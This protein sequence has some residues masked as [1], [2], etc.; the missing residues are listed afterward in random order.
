MTAIF[1][2]WNNYGFSL[3]SDSNQT[4]SKDN[5]TW[6]DPV[7]KV[8]LLEKHQIAIGAAGDSF[9]RGVEINEIFRTWERTLPI[10]GFPELGDYFVD[11]V[12]WFNRQTFVKSD[13]NFDGLRSLMRACFEKIKTFQNSSVAYSDALDFEKKVIASFECDRSAFNLLG[14]NWDLYASVSDS[15]QEELSDSDE[16]SDELRAKLIARNPEIESFNWIFDENDELD[17][18]VIDEIYPIFSE[19]FE[20]ELDFNNDSDIDILNVAISLVSNISFSVDDDLEAILIGYGENDWLP[21]GISFKFYTSIFGL[22]RL[23]VSKCSNPNINWYMSI[24]VDAAIT[25]LAHGVSGDR[26]TQIMELAS[27]YIEESAIAD[28]SEKIH[29]QSNEKFHKTLSKIDF[30]TIDRLEYVS[31]LFVQIEALKS[32]LDQPVPGVGGDIRVIS[33]TKNTRRSKHFKEFEN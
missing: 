9:H 10:D 12:G 22:R 11:F 15:L 19:V 27:D 6:V 7:E 1:A 4:A 13:R 28:F 29:K 33:M 30:L 31:K 2:I 14:P 24:A 20:R 25:E 18:E 26:L 23:Q 8:I 5:Q 21:S 17:S 32:F 3:A 16:Q